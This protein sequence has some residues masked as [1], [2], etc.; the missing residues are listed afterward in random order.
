MQRVL[1]TVV[2]LGLLVA[3][4]AAFAITE[5]L[6]LVRSPIYGTLVSKTLSPVCGCARGKATIRV[7]LRRGDVVTL[8][9]L[10]RQRRV[11]RTLAAGEYVPRG[12]AFF[13][14]NGLT[15]SGTRAPDGV[16]QPEI[17]LAQQR[18]TILFP[19]RIV[20]DTRPPRVLSVSASRDLI[21]PDGDGVGDSVRIRYRL[22]TPAHVL[23]YL[24]RRLLI[25]GRFHKPKDE[26]TWYGKVDGVALRPGSY[27]L[28]VGAVDLAGNQTPFAA[29]RP[30]TIRVRYIAVPRQVVVH[31]PGSRFTVPVDTDA[32]RYRWTLNGRQ[33]VATGTL[34]RLRAPAKRGTYALVL[35]EH[36]HTARA[37]IVVGGGG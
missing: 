8:T 21:S 27:T 7:K 11:V 3:T 29:R 6:K 22:D 34:L 32:R 26:V 36:G 15:A 23:V 4:A 19:N 17:H 5:H 37:S 16:Y 24:G 28:E 25:R 13:S 33:G 10:D 18:R 30:L 14:W 20:L 9:I 12:P 2:L 1:S 35:L 31:A